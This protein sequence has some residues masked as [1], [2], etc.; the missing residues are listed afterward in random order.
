[1]IECLALSG[2]IIEA[3]KLMSTTMNA[4]NDLGLFAEEYDP[5]A[6]QMLGNFPQAFSHIGYINAVTALLSGKLSPGEQEAEPSL[7]R[8]MRRMIP[9]KLTLNS[10]PH[11][12]AGAP[13]KIDAGLKIMAGRLRSGFVDTER[14]RIDYAAMKP[15]ASFKEYR[16]F[17]QGLQGFDPASL[18]TDQERKAFWINIYNLLI[19]HG[20]IA[21]DIRRSVL[22]IVNFFGRIGYDIGGQFFTPDEIEHGILRKNRP[23]PAFPIKPFRSSDPRLQLTVET[24]DPRIDFAL[25][26]ASASSPRLDH[27]DAETI[28]RQ[29]DNAARRFIG[30]GG[31]ELDEQKRELRLP[32]IFQWYSKDF[33]QNQDEVVNYLLEFCDDSLRERIVS[34]RSELRVRYQP[35]DWNLNR[36]ES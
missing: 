33:G 19:M 17:A 5:R 30:E 28:D 34:M 6:Q 2:N 13:G 11:P 9:L 31:V 24:F 15:S 10:S 4:A 36:A 8:R 26:C 21:L 27:Y 7:M 1:M 23:H 16:Q 25:V 12:P 3:E 20:V 32:R 14:N 35:Y 29:L 18:R 22:E